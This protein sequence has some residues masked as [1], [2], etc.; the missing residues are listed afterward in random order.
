MQIS[1]F[2][3][4]IASVN[5]QLLKEVNFEIVFRNLEHVLFREI[6]HKKFHLWS[7]VIGQSASVYKHMI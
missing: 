1:N 5:S 6:S 3:K 2:R 4:K 7:A